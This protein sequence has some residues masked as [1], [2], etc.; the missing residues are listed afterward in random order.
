MRAL[1]GSEYG[2]SSVICILKYINLFLYEHIIFSAGVR[3]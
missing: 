2:C 3:W 1:R